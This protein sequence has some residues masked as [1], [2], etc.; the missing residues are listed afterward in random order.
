MHP[1]R[2]RGQES[3]CSPSNFGSLEGCGIGYNSEEG[4]GKDAV[5]MRTNAAHRGSN[6]R[7]GETEIRMKDGRLNGR[8]KPAA[9]TLFQCSTLFHH[10]G[11]SRPNIHS[12]STGPAPWRKISVLSVCSVFY[13]AWS[14]PL[15]PF[16]VVHEMSGRTLFKFETHP[17]E[18][19]R[20]VMQWSRYLPTT[21]ILR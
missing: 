16:I 11:L 19:A 13:G 20:S 10:L 9:P 12:N 18:R 1:R 17:S 2:D 14:Q 5:Q 7:M 15:F 21:W 4:E 6:E 8:K 3:A